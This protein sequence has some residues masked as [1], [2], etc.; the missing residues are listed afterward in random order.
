[1]YLRIKNG[2]KLNA[3]FFAKNG[4]KRFCKW[5]ALIVAKETMSV[6]IEEYVLQDKF[7]QLI[8][9][10]DPN[11]NVSGNVLFNA[12]YGALIA[13]TA[14]TAGVL[15]GLNE[16]LTDINGNEYAETVDMPSAAQF[17][18]RNTV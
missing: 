8:Y 13:S 16:T 12:Y 2:S 17:T 14:T 9:Q 1:M 11:R 7:E 18:G 5:C 15:F 3:D 4:K 10:W 6:F